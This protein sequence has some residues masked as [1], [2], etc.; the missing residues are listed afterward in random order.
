[1]ENKQPQTLEEAIQMLI[2]EAQEQNVLVE[3]TDMKDEDFNPHHTIGQDIRNKWFLWWYEGNPYDKW[4]KEIP[5]LVKWFNEELQIFHADD[6]S[7]I[8]LDCFYLK[9]KG[10]PYENKIKENVAAAI[11]H[12]KGEGFKD[13]IFKPTKTPVEPKKPEPEKKLKTISFYKHKPKVGIGVFRHVGFDDN[14]DYLLQDIMQSLKPFSVR[15]VDIQ[16]NFENVPDFDYKEYTKNVQTCGRRM[17]EFFGDWE[18]GENLDY[19]QDRG[20]DGIR[21]SFCGSAKYEKFIEVLHAVID[22]QPG[23]AVEKASGKN[24]KYYLETPESKMIK[25]YVQHIPKEVMHN[26]AMLEALNLKL[27]DACIK[28]ARRRGEL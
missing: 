16:I 9:I 26:P 18:R 22:L 2:N 24:Y 13:G 11:K 25:F 3:L 23:Y 8:I 4:P 21:C 7:G 19:W 14:K 17:N 15:R 5:A 27:M 1:M 10:L 12:W 20:T 28:S 6:M